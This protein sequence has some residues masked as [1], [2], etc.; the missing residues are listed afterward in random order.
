MEGFE[1]KGENFEI[2]TLQTGSLFHCCPAA[3]QL[4]EMEAEFLQA[5]KQGQVSRVRDVLALRS[6]DVNC[7]DADTVSYI[8]TIC[9]RILAEVNFIRSKEIRFLPCTELSAAIRENLCEDIEDEVLKISIE[10]LHSICELLYFPY[11]GAG[12][13]LWDKGLVILDLPWLCQDIFGK[14]GSY[15]FSSMCSNKE[16]WSR[17]EVELELHLRQD[18]CPH[19]IV[20]LLVKLELVFNTGS[21]HFIV[22]AWLRKEKSSDAWVREDCFNLYQGMVYRWHDHLGLF[23]Q[24]FFLRLRLHLMR[25]FTRETWTVSDSGAA[26]R[27]QHERFVIWKGGIKCTDM[28][29]ALVQV[30]SDGLSLSVT[31]RGYRPPNL[32]N[33]A[34]DTQS[35]CFELLKGISNH[36][37]KLLRETSAGC[38]WDRFY[39]SPRHLSN[40]MDGSNSDLTAYTLD[41]ILQTERDGLTLCSK[42]LAI[43]ENPWDI[44]MAGY[45]STLLKSLQWNAS[46]RWLM[47]RTLK[48]LCSHLDPSHPSVCIGKG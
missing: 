23:S 8:P 4:Q 19:L 14:F 17:E 26:E 16:K 12:S 37:E 43:E 45:D 10:Y 35:K 13:S 24:A 47:Y 15:T 18:K 1:N 39:S 27:Q 20:E 44:L 21:G 36:V 34:L 7:C 9:S 6:V 3:S 30:S 11:V 25:H 31:V 5:V 48:D 29:E 28:A 40:K 46:V 38:E 32:N 22:P 33:P 42:Y 41:Q 2:E